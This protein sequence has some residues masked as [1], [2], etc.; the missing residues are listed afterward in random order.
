MTT[1]TTTIVTMLFDLK[2]LKDASP[3]TRPLDFYLERCVSVLR[4]P[5]PMLIFCDEITYPYLKTIR[6]TEVAEEI[7]SQYVIQRLETYDYYRHSW[8]IIEQNRKKKGTPLDTR[9]TSSYFLMGM[10]K[11][12]ALWI[13]A[14][15]QDF[16]TEYYAWIDIGCAHI[17]RH[18]NT[19]VADMVERPHPKIAVCYIHYRS[20]AELE[21]ME[22]YMKYG[23][24][25][26]IASTAY[27]MPGSHVI[28]F[29]TLMFQIFYE[30]LFRGVGHT[31]ETVM[32]YAYDR[33][34][35]L[36]T[37]FY[38]DYGS[39]FVNYREIREDI[40]TIVCCF[41]QQAQSK[42]RLD[43]AKQAVRALKQSQWVET[44][45]FTPYLQSVLDS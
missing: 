24:P 43:L 30:K 35:E 28:P 37:L 4:L 1:T 6:D 38:G 44:S 15:R 20:R 26:G 41:I 9:N 33:K 34:P 29:Y 8:D 16:G 2:N 17:C 18:L 12:L 11:P 5:Y 40:A 10:F 31:D 32:V 22:D 27:T 45:E 19:Y 7:P 39:I 23:G 21:S 3:A 25:C 36:F 42:G 13:A 14:L